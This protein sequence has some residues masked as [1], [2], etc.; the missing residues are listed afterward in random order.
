ML[1]D[2][3]PDILTFFKEIFSGKGIEA[4]QHFVT[5]HGVFIY[6]LLCIIVFCET[7]LVVTPFLPG[8]SL[9]FAAGAVVAIAGPATETLNL[10]LLGLLLFASAIAGDNVNYFLGKFL[11]KKGENAKLFG[12]FTIRKDYLDKTHK[13]YEKYGGQTI[14][15]ARFVPIVR[16]FAP[17]V[18]GVG[19]MEYRKYIGFCL[20]G[21]FLWVASMLACG[22][23]FGQIEFVQKH[24]EMV[25]IGIIGFS[26]LPVTIGILRAR[27]KK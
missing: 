4:I 13:F 12:L 8:D 23:L 14:I 1:L 24:F 26:L 16:T 7:G 11:A 25:V 17:F 21:G 15:M 22:Y 27:S 19:K 2:I 9:L 10:P 20:I 3:F 5:A 6:V 18:A